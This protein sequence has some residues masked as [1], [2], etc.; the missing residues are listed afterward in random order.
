M[1]NKVILVVSDLHAPYTHPDA[2]PFLRVIKN[3][4][5]PTRVIF[6]GDEI[7]AHALSYHDHD[8][9]L[10][11]AGKELKQAVGTHTWHA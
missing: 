2:V 5:K 3:R 1:N 4:F 9:D 6:S 8:P 7:D 11:S 10:D